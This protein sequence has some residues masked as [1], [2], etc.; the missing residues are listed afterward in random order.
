MVVL[1]VV[2]VDVQW[3]ESM[4]CYSAIW[5]APVATMVDG[6]SNR[7]KGLLLVYQGQL[8]W[9]LGLGLTLYQRKYMD[10][11][12]RQKDITPL[13]RSRMPHPYHPVL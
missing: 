13:Y 2:K 8:M 9:T 7:E 1:E 12:W 11:H 10:H 4:S 6:L 3:N 5:Y